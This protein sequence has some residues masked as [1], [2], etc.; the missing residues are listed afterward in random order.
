MNGDKNNKTD[1]PPH[2]G[3]DQRN[4]AQ[5]L[6]AS[7]NDLED[8]LNQARQAY[9]ILYG[10]TY[11]GKNYDNMYKNKNLKRKRAGSSGKENI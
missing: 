9:Q 10:D 11:Q 6:L 2:F 1:C 4:H 5:S 8:R 3:I 7:I